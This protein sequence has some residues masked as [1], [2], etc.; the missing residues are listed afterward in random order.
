M[1][2]GRGGEGGRGSTPHNGLNRDALVAPFSGQRYI[3]E[4]G[5]HEFHIHKNTFSLKNEKIIILI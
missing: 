3:K 4:K 2:G 5:F 1:T